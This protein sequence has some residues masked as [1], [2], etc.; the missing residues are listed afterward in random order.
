VRARKDKV[1]TRPQ[2]TGT[3]T[4]CAIKWIDSLNTNHQLLYGV[5]EPKDREPAEDYPAAVNNIQQKSNT[6]K[7]KDAMIRYLMSQL[8]REVD[9]TIKMVSGC[10]AV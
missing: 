3:L 1:Y 7:V 2:F 5:V 4:R 9:S 10:G 8:N 6:L